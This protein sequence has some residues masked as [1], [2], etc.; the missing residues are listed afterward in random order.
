[1]IIIATTVNFVSAPL[2]AFVN[3][4]PRAQIILKDSFH[5]Y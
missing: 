3:G 1:M 4:A 5:Y 2:D